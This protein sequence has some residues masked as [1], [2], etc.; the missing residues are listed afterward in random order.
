MPADRFVVGFALGRWQSNCYVIG[1]RNQGTAVVVDPGENSATAVPDVLDREDVSCAAI[2]LTHGHI[3]HLWSAPDLAE[4]CD[5]PVLLH[6]DDRWLW[7][8]PTAGFGGGIPPEAMERL[9]GGPWDPPSE[10]LQDIED[11][12]KLAYAGATFEVRH[13]PG[14]TPGHCTFLASDLGD[15]DISFGSPLDLPDPGVLFS[16]DLVFRGSIGRTD[17]PRGSHDQ[18]LRSIARTFLDLED[19]TLV[20][21]GHGRETTVGRERRSN[22]FLRDLTAE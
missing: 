17:F 3:D 1:D 10:R 12:T 19:D 14:H 6:P 18:Q 8:D 13:S 9:L 4:R 5:V 16:G 21:S 11:G 2:L 22:P 7:D 20:L 15:A